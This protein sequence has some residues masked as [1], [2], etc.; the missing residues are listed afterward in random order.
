MAD[1]T[2]DSIHH[3][4]SRNTYIWI[5]IIYKLYLFKLLHIYYVLH[6]EFLTVSLIDTIN[7]IE[8]Y[9]HKYV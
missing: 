9:K 3:I 1:I 7:S 2:A 4:K 5:N 8:N 6:Y